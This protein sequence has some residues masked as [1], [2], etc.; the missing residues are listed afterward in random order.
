MKKNQQNTIGPQSKDLNVRAKMTF[1][2][3]LKERKKKKEETAITKIF[4]FH[5]LLLTSK[6]TSEFSLQSG[7]TPGGLCYFS[8]QRIQVK[9]ER[10]PT[11]EQIPRHRF[12]QGTCFVD[13]LWINNQDTL[14]AWRE[15]TIQ[16]EKYVNKYPLYNGMG[17]INRNLNKVQ[18]LKSKLECLRISG[19]FPPVTFHR[20]LENK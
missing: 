14:L 19:I 2:S 7:Q 6:K 12:I 15:L 10:Q 5:T 4:T 20:I 11:S 1:C 17:A 3:S 8:C 18:W 13:F 9:R 16:W